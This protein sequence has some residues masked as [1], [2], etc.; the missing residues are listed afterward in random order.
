MSQDTRQHTDVIAASGAAADDESSTLTAQR[1]DVDRLFAVASKTF[2]SM[3]T[4]NS[5]QF[6]EASR[7]TGGQ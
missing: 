7:Q 4:G 6:I 5:Q 2:E 3:R 1:A